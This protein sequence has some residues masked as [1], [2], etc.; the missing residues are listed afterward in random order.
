MPLI[1]FCLLNPFLTARPLPPIEP[2]LQA[3]ASLTFVERLKAVA[4]HRTSVSIS[5]RTF[6]PNDA[7]NGLR[8]KVEA[9]AVQG[10]GRFGPFGPPGRSDSTVRFEA[11][12][13]WG[14]WLWV[15][16]VGLGFGRRPGPG[17]GAAPGQHATRRLGDR[18]SGGG[19]P[20]HGHGLHPARL[21]PLFPLDPGRIS[22]ARVLRG[23]RGLRSGTAGPH[24]P[25][26]QGLGRVRIL[27]RPAPWVFSIL[28]A[29]YAFFWHAR[30]WNAASRL[31]LTYAWVDR[32]TISIDGLED[33]THD[34]ALRAGHYYTD[35]TPGF[36]LMGALPYAILKPVLRL[37]DHPL[38]AKGFAYWPAD[39][40][41]TLGTSGLCTALAGAILSEPGPRS[42]LRPPTIGAGWSGLWPG[43]PRLRLRDVWRTATRSRRSACWRRSPCCGATTLKAPS[44][45][46]PGRVLRQLRQRRRD[47]GRPGLGDPGHST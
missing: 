12:Q 6:F 29:S 31:M 36:S 32:G 4:E 44:R 45:V 21:G 1:T 14:A 34:I 7:L 28:L 24:P 30:D 38:K 3:I 2:R 5:V 47:P 9:V 43:D 27:H 37:P 33:Q 19:R 15:P 11:R 23:G 16:W 40:W 26:T 41:V 25:R 13:D 35:K 10:F 39:Y 46:G 22:A 20:G 8:E 42:R 18:A 17:P